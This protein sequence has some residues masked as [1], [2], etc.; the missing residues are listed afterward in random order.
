MIFNNRTVAIRQVYNNPTSLFDA[1]TIYIYNSE[2]NQTKVS[3]W[4]WNFYMGT[5]P[6]LQL[7]SHFLSTKK[8]DLK[9]TSFQECHQ[10]SVISMIR[11]GSAVG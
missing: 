6:F 3:L 7:A 2:V 5:L 8:T 9:P 10:T 4:K 1:T 11:F